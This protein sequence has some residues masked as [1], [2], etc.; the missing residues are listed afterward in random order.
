MAC[1]SATTHNR[2]WCDWDNTG[3][4]TANEEVLSANS[5]ASASGSVLVP[6]FATLNAPL[7]L[8]LIADY[9]FSAIPAPCQDPQYGQAE[10]Y[11]D[12]GRREPSHRIAAFSADPIFT[13]QWPCAIQ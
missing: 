11:T 6:A 8:R 9:D 3:T 2:G 12:R 1:G 10:D 13:L 5:V 4:F 7:R